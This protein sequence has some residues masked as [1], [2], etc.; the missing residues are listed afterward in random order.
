MI[1][2]NNAIKIKYIVWVHHE[3]DVVGIMTLEQW[4]K[5]P[6]NCVMLDYVETVCDL[7]FAEHIAKQLADKLNY[8]F[9]PFE[10]FAVEPKEPFDWDVKEVNLE[11]L[12]NLEDKLDNK[13]YMAVQ[14]DLK[15]C[16]RAYVDNHYQRIDPIKV[17]VLTNKETKE[18]KYVVKG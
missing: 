1:L 6:D 10:F 13:T 2:V 18:V 7:D 14:F 11:D 16:G 4:D 15:F 9:T 12:L 5:E 17:Q 3:S 8:D